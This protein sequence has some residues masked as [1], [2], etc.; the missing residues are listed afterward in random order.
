M[1][2][3]ETALRRTAVVL[4]T[5]ILAVASAHAQPLFTEIGALAGI[6]PF[7]PT[8]GIASGLAAADFDGDGDIDLFIPN[9]NGVA[10]QLYINTG[11]GQFIESAADR[12]V[13]SALDN[14]G[15]LW[16]DYDGDSRLD[17][18]VTRDAGPS[19][20]TLYR[21]N[22]NGTFTDVTTAA[23][24]FVAPE[25]HFDPLLPGQI[26]GGASAADIDR[27]SHLDLCIVTWNGRARLFRNQ[28][29]GTFIE[30]TTSAGLHLYPRK[31]WQPYFFDF[32]AD[33]WTDLYL[34]VDFD[35]NLLFLNQGDGTFIESAAAF[36][37]ANDMNDMGVT[38][39]D[40][41]NDG[42]FDI[43][44]SN[45]FWPD[46][47][48]GEQLHNVLLRNDS[49]GAA[50][51][52]TEVSQAHQVHDGGW[53][54]GV[55]YFDADNDGWLDIA[56]TNGYVF[57]AD[58]S[59]FFRNPG[60]PPFVF[61]DQSAAV[62]FNDTLWGSALAAF[63]YDRDGDLDLVQVC[64]E[65][66]VRLLANSPIGE[67]AENHHLVVRP[68]MLGPNSHAIGAVVRVTAGDLRMMRHITAGTGFMSQEPAEA[69]FG[70]AAHAVADLVEIAWPD[71]S[72]TQ[73]F[74]QPANTLLDVTHGGPGDLDADGEIDLAD[75]QRFVDCFTGPRTGAIAY[76]LSCRG[77]DFLGDGDV[78]L[79]DWSIFA[80]LLAN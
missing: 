19:I 4:G 76:P 58:A 32:N 65:G 62:Q 5:S 21:Q 41:D 52:Y 50:H 51:S 35:A 48:T 71:G 16:F 8:P 67:S 45:I 24:L 10:D 44:I 33:G 29:D 59:R 15:A 26:R 47:D 61:I 78:D 73:L 72:V 18:L 56:E 14:R 31:F 70:L 42:D 57:W 74:D 22:E 40:Y 68:R 11:D 79:E 27:D 17:L 37:L 20:L 75:L 63:D 9:G 53:G 49:L 23:G 13:D 2:A 66:Q 12:G 36:G 25:P 30:I 3:G 60:A 69:H 80:A 39:G 28:R 54:W 64:M 77:A 55:T 6:Q 34:M 1:P 46:P 38:F 7:T 43:Y